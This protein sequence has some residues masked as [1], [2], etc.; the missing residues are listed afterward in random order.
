MGIVFRADPSLRCTV[1]VWDGDIVEDDVREHIVRLAA[2]PDW[3]P[4][5]L[6]LTDM[7]TIGSATIPDRDL[8][9]L[10]YE[11]TSLPDELK[12]AVIVRPEAI[13]QFGLKFETATQEMRAATFV[14]F[15]DACQHLAVN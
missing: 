5:P 15:Y 3:P 8:L 6:H 12:V 13:E 7:T 2:D 14:D 1:S 4:G 11:G 10:L 9:A